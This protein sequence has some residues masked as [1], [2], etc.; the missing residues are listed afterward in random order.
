MTYKNCQFHRVIKG[1]V[2]Q[3]GDF[4]K[5]NGSGGECVFPGKK[6]GFKVMF[7]PCP[8]V[9]RNWPEPLWDEAPG[10]RTSRRRCCATASV[11]LPRPHPMRM[12]PL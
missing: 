6:T 4:V 12:S 8:R 11:P 3:G 5:N 2:A 10:S 7:H 1:F 9:S